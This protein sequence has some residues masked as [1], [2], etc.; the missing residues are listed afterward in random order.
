MQEPIIFRATPQWFC[1]VDAF[2]EEA[3]R[4]CENVTWMPEWGGDRMKQMI[5][6]RADW[7]ISRQRHWGLPIPVFYC[8]DCGKPGLHGRDHRSH[9]EAVCR[10]GLQLLV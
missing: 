10:E 5:R 8:A 1:S 4:A 7:C 3:C 6:E 2:K 9:L